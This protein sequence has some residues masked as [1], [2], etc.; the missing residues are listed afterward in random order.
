MAQKKS[1]MKPYQRELSIH[2]RSYNRTLYGADTLRSAISRYYH[3]F[4][5]ARLRR[6][7]RSLSEA[8]KRTLHSKAVLFAK[9]EF[10]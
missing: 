2:S 10:K 4:C 6:N 8:E 7:K 1:K 3:G 5:I 9:K